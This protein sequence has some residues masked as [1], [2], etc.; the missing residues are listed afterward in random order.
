[1]VNSDSERIIC[2]TSPLAKSTFFYVQEV[3]YLKALQ[4]YY[5]KCE[6]QD[7]YL[8]AVV[9]DGKGQLSYKGKKYFLEKGNCFFI[10]CKYTH[11][12][13]SLIDFPWEIQWV[14]FNG[15]T[16][17]NYYK[18]FLSNHSN[19]VFPQSYTLFTDVLS[20]IYNV[21]SNKNDFNEINNSRLLV[22]MLTLT[23]TFVNV[24]NKPSKKLE[25]KINQIKLFIDNNF[26]QQIYLDQL[27]EKYDINKFYLV[28]QF[29]KAF[30]I[31]ISRYLIEKR[32]AY[33]KRLL[34]FTDKPI[35]F[36]SEICGYYDRNY[37]CK[38]FRD[39]VEYT[40]HNYRKLWRNK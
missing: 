19:V 37:F 3:G 16:S 36:I 20:L 35:E 25:N 24:E 15:A 27:A 17:K 34:R 21:N 14:Y 39:V 18:A 26:T 11:E 5:C 6:K 29:K 13:S 32:I 8:F 23:L 10:D 40:P 1:M 2:T 7:S 33:A 9:L 28:R 12:Y 38:Q 4:Y 22:D 31:T 30:G